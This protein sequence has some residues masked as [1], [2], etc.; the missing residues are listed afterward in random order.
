MGIRI[1]ADL[2]TLEA[3][4]GYLEKCWAGEGLPEVRALEPVL[5]RED[6]HP[7]GST[8]AHMALVM[9][10]A[11]EMELDLPERLACL[12]H[13]LGKAVTWGDPSLREKRSHKGHDDIGAQLIGE[14]FRREGLPREMEGVCRLTA[15]W[16]QRVHMI[17][18][19]GAAGL[20]RLLRS[21][22]MEWVVERDSGADNSASFEEFAGKLSRVCEADARGRLGLEALPYPQSLALRRMARCWAEESSQEAEGERSRIS[23]LIRSAKAQSKELASQRNPEWAEE[24]CWQEAERAIE[25]RIENG[26]LPR[27]PK[28]LEARLFEAKEGAFR[29]RAGEAGISSENPQEDFKRLRKEGS[30][31]RKIF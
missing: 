12:L 10:Q 27:K 4:L 11:F 2:E 25:K 26:E 3:A 29:E 20:A 19:T 31:P 13:D 6:Y 5:E 23:E 8:R 15:R 14:V 7:E 18:D 24:R 9:R 1:E 30:P 17:G 28:S 21:L 16:H 22:E